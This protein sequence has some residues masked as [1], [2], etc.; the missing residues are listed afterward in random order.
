MHFFLDTN[1]RDRIDFRT[2]P[3]A[4]SR[5]EDSFDSQIGNELEAPS[6]NWGLMALIALSFE[7]NDS[8][9]TTLRIRRDRRNAATHRFLVVHYEGFHESTN[10]TDHIHIDDLRKELVA[11]LAMAK[12]AILYVAAMIHC[13]WESN[14]AD[15]APSTA[16]VPIDFDWMDVDDNEF[17]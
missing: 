10:W 2:F 15:Q 13:R 4:D 6:P 8:P 5:S 9:N 1:R 12:N 14:C 17:F 11:Q 7:L 16:P 3:Y